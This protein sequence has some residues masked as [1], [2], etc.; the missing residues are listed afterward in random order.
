M[1][2]YKI[3]PSIDVVETPVDERG[4]LIRHLHL[5]KGK[6]IP[7]HKADALVTVV[8]LEG[9]VMFFPEFVQGLQHHTFFEITH[10][11]RTGQFFFTFIFISCR[12]NNAFT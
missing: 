2:F 10:G 4:R 3:D 6:E 1:K 7:E 9:R 8:C 12:L 11:L 5:A